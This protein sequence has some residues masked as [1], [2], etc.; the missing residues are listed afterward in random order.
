MEICKTCI[1]PLEENLAKFVPAAALPFKKEEGLCNL[2]HS[3]KNDPFFERYNGENTI[4]S[5]ELQKFLES[6]KKIVFAYS[7]GLDS[8]VVL[9]LLNSKCQARSIELAL[10]TVDHGFKGH[11]TKA[12]IEAIIKFEGLEKQ[13]QWLD[14]TKELNQEGKRKFDVYA[15]SYKQGILPCGKICNALIDV[16]YRRILDK[17][18]ENILIT[19]GD[20]P[21]FSPRLGRFSIFWEKPKFTV[22]RCAAALKLGKT[23]NRDYV[24]QNNIPWRDPG[25]GGYD[26]DCLVPGAIL[27]KITEGKTSTFETVIRETPVVLE[28]FSE[29][30]RWGV[31]NR[32]DAISRMNQLEVSDSTSYAEMNVLVQNDYFKSSSSGGSL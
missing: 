18:Q 19:G 30:V 29:R 27:R 31:I 5:E 11:I 8:T 10:F 21:K 20:T 22:L 12:N 1:I 26:T 2:C 16:A 23:T 4:F 28:Y 7:G 3:L 9:N 24:K 17:E 13:H 14:I 25:C 32:Q 6:R 15:E